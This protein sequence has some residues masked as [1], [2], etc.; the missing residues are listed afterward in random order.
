VIRAGPAN[1]PG[2]RADPDRLHEGKAWPQLVVIGVYNVGEETAGTFP[3]QSPV[4]VTS[5]LS[6]KGA[7][8]SHSE[9]V[10]APSVQ[11]VV[12]FQDSSVP[13]NS[14]CPTPVQKDAGVSEG[15]LLLVAWL[16]LLGACL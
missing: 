14:E 2:P 5:Q 15:G 1:P 13:F 10:V 6:N 11:R 16:P 4:Q 7:S 8:H 12:A 9:F 3:G